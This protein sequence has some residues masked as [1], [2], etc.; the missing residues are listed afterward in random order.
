[1]KTLDK[2]YFENPEKY[3]PHGMYCYTVISV[4]WKTGIMKTDTCPFWDYDETQE[5]QHGGYCHYLKNGDW[6]RNKEINDKSI[7]I[8]EKDKGK[9]VSEV[10]GEDFPSSLLWDQCKECGINDD[11]QT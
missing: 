11:W 8:S 7:I 5:E 9:T 1:M 6:E 3:I 2:K 4:D 10:I